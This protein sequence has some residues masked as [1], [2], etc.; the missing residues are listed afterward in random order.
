MID[1]TYTVYMISVINFFKLWVLYPQ[2]HV[3]DQYLV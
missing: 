1:I 3:Y 2:T